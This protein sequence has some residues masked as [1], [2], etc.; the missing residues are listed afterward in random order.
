MMEKGK[1][2]AFQMALMILPPIISTSI[3]AVPA[4]TGSY[5]HR[6]MWISPILASLNGFF[7]AFIVYQLHKIYPKETIIQYSQHIVGRILGKVLGLIILFFFL[8]LSGTI[9]REYTVFV[10]DTFFPKTPMIVVI[11][12]MALVSAFAVRGGVEVLGRAAQLFVPIFMFPLLLLILLIPNFK[13][14]NMFPIMERGIMPPVMGAAQP[15]V[16]FAEVFLMSILLPFLTDREK[17]MKWSMISV[18]VALLTMVYLDIVSLFVLGE[19]A[20]D[21][22]YPVFIVFRHISVATFFE[23]LESILMV[24]WVLGVFVKFSVFYYALVL[25]TAQW[26]DLSNYRPIVFP[27]G[28]LIILFGIWEYPNFQEL[29]RLLELSLPFMKHLL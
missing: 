23:H 24:V 2:S 20:S 4:V 10:I 25:G 14:E 27:L 22:T 6:D 17:G 5:A 9:C 7:T 26:L 13:P 29:T 3:L 18:V 21:Y 15:M 12:S 16:W 1:I 8:Y 11:G 19:S 28:F